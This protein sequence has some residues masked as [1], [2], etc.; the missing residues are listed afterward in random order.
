MMWI[1]AVVYDGKVWVLAGRKSD[2]YGGE[3]DSTGAWWSADA[4]KTWT[5]VDAP[6]PATHAD[7]V[8]AT[9]QDGIVMASG[10]QVFGKVFR[11]KG[12]RKK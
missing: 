5:H 7:G 10:N 3:G 8:T 12:E 9:E 11:L 6:W 1:D 4:G 2:V